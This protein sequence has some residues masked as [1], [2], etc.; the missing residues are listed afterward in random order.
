MPDKRTRFDQ[1]VAGIHQR[2]GL[3]A[4]RRGSALSQTNSPPHIATGFAALD[5]ISGCDGVPLG[6]FTLLSGRTT[7]GKLTVAY[8]ILAHAQHSTRTAPLHNVGILDLNYSCDPDYLARCG[9]DLEH[10]LIVRPQSTR[11]AIELLRDLVR[12]YPLRVLLVDGLP[13]LT[14]EGQSTQYL[15]ALLPQVH[16]LYARTRSALICLDEPHPPWQRW[17]QRVR[18]SLGHY[19]S[20]HVELQRE[21]W[22]DDEQTFKGYRAQAK[23]LKSQWARTGQTAPV[24]IVFNG[25][26]RAR[27]TW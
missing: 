19:I 23:I 26:V 27:E 10:L 9:I 17:L 18:S 2:Y 5:A 22:V 12:E 20:L 3:E 24:E 16:R 7:S 15:D 6:A 25:T 13:D 11:Q 8:K 1:A 21:R 14:A 4:L